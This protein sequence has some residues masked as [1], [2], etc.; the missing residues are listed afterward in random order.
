MPALFK[1]LLDLGVYTF[2]R[3][4]TIIIAPPLT[5]ERA[6]LAEGIDALRTVLAE[7]LVGV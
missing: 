4:N 6:E 7:L 2:G 1:R 3:Y 5:I